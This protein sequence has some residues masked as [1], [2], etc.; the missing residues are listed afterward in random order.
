MEKKKFCNSVIK[1]TNKIKEGTQENFTEYFIHES[2]SKDCIDLI[3]SKADL[4]H[5]TEDAAKQ[6]INTLSEI[7]INHSDKIRDIVFSILEP[8]PHIDS[9]K[10]LE[11]VIQWKIKEKTDINIELTTTYMRQLK[12]EYHYNSRFFIYL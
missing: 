5:S 12:R 7:D 8:D 3:E 4:F 10:L 1:E 6:K 9:R 2:H 11:N